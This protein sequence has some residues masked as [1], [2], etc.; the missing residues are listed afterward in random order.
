[1]SSRPS[2]A[3][4]RLRAAVTALGLAAGLL[5]AAPTL[6]Q[7]ATESAPP[8]P[9]CRMATLVV[10]GGAG[11]GTDLIARALAEA[12]NRT[13]MEPPLRVRNIDGNDGIDGGRAVLG[14]PGDGCMMLAAHQGLLVNFLTWRAPFAWQDFR[15]VALLTRTPMV[16]VAP[17]SA[18]FSNA[19]GMVSAARNGAV[20]AGVGPG[21]IAEFTLRAM[22]KAA[23]IEL[24]YDSIAGA[25]ERVAALLAADIDLAVVPPALAKRLAETQT[26]RS[27]AVTD[28]E[29]STTVPSVETLR[30]Q[31][32]PFD[33]A[34][35]FGILLPPS[36]S[37]DL[38]VRLADGLEKALNDPEFQKTM[39]GY[40]V[41]IDFRP[42]T[43]YS[44]YWENLMASWRDIAEEAGYDR[45][46]R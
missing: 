45:T 18:G 41:R 1:M 15:H 14:A 25:R 20:T 8:A 33:Y 38:A 28:R 10:G 23:G 19:Q 31:G 29:P 5:A 13:G 30:D 42:L 11:S 16:I 34:I 32:V 22:A 12:A 24:E 4:R 17:V 21:T 39:A 26:V 2:T 44:I 40:D 43:Q 3:A 35:D 7:T 9:T 36:A 46:S 27:I 6:A 37:Q